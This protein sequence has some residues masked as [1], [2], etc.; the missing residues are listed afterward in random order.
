[1]FA[2]SQNDLPRLKSVKSPSAKPPATFEAALKELETL[3]QTLENGG[4]PLEE[5]LLAYERGT[6]LLRHCQ[7][8]LAQAEQKIRI[9]DGTELR[10]FP[11]SAA[12]GETSGQ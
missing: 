4:T 5:S 3:V 8:T 9:L 1:M 2:C 10:D 6:V 12:S 7:Q 11:A